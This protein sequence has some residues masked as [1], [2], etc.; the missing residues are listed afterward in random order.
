MKT[1]TKRA[2]GLSEEIRAA[3]RENHVP[4][5]KEFA[6]AAGLRWVN[7]TGPGIRREGRGKHFVFRSA[8]GRVVTEEKTLGRIKSLVLPPAW[9]GVWISPSARYAH[10]GDGD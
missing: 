4:E 9:K 2:D 1:Q 5:P 3:A 7:D 10:S 6:E 8:T